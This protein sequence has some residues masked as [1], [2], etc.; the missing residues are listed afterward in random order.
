MRNASQHAWRFGGLTI[1]RG[2]LIATLTIVAL[3]TPADARTIRVDRQ[4]ESI[5]GAVLANDGAVERD[6]YS[7][8]EVPPNGERESTPFSINFFGTVYDSFFINENGVISFGAPLSGPP[9]NVD[10]VFTAGVPVIV[11][12]YADADMAVQG[13]AALA[14]TFGINMFVNLRSTYQGSSD[15]SIVDEMQVAFFGSQSTTDFRLELNYGLLQWQSG[16][17]DGGVNGL[18]GIAPRIG[19]SDGFGRTFEVAGSGENGVLLNPS[20]DAPCAPGSLSV[21]CNDYFF[22]FIDGLPYRNGIPIFPTAV[23]E[24]GTAALVL[25]ALVLAG[26]RPKRVAAV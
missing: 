15:P 22:E 4:S 5:P 21:G 10:D 2:A 16:D 20:F 6:I 8:A 26:L 14:F 3:V 25:L 18:G 1:A 24:P 23:V 11:P 13:G 12:F 19:F 7:V 9:R 17:L